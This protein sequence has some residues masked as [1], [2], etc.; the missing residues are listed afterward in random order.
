LSLK[1][2]IPCLDTTVDKSGRPMVV[3]GIEFEGLRYAGDPL[4]LAKKYDREGADELVF[5]DITASIEKRGTMLDVVGK[6]A[7]VLSIPLGVGGGVSSIED[8]RRVVEAGATKVSMNT[9]AVRNPPLIG[10]VSSLFGSSAVVVA[11]D[12]RSRTVDLEGKTRLAL[13]DGGEGWYEVVILG[14]SQPTGLDTVE[15]A[16]RVQDLGAGE[17]LLTCKDRDGTKDGYDLTVTEAVAEAVDLPVIASGG[18]GEPEHMFEAFHEAGADA[19]LAA[20]IFHY[21]EY[22]IGQVKEY[23]KEKG[24]PVRI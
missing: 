9:A 2:I 10:R 23:L 3:K 6:I 8:F 12:C 19:C 15:W 16:R 17:I 13:P 14:G 20:S 7:E 11:I 5:L 22:T 18:V 24:I 21:G 1:R 4:S